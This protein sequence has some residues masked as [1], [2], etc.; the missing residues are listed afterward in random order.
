MRKLSAVSHGITK[1]VKPKH[2][3]S[4][5]QPLKKRLRIHKGGYSYRIPRFT[6]FECNH[7]DIVGYSACWYKTVRVIRPHFAGED[8]SF[9]KETAEEHPTVT[10]LYMPMDKGE[11]VTELWESR[12]EIH[13][14]GRPESRR[15]QSLVV[16]LLASHKT[17]HT[18]LSTDE[19]KPGSHVEHWPTL[20]ALPWRLDS[21]GYAICESFTHLYRRCA[22]RATPTGFR[23]PRPERR[24]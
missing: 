12:V 7:P 24:A 5:P 4:I 11:L 9:Y 1:E 22:E 15:I 2:M 23:V 13:D 10:W 20:E 18:D 14:V 21:A 3:W 16:R 17:I 19:D 8:M 6:F